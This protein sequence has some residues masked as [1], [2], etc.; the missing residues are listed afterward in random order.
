M[1]IEL[2]LQFYKEMKVGTE[3]EPDGRHSLKTV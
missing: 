2:L 3:T 1:L